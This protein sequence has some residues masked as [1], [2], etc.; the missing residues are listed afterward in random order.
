MSAKQRQI[1]EAA[2]SK[3]RRRGNELLQLIELDTAHFDMFDMP[4]MGEYE[5]YMC[6]YGRSN[7]TQVRFCLRGG[8]NGGYKSIFISVIIGSLLMVVFPWVGGYCCKMIIE[9]KVFLG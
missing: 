9:C 6:S 2:S 3:T 8:V 4:P 5:L 7:T 1:T